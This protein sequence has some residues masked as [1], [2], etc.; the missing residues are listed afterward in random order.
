MSTGADCEPSPL[1]II[2]A[3]PSHFT[4]LKYSFFFSHCLFLGLSTH[5]GGWEA[6]PWIR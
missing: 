5:F 1:E 3:A 4:S 6:F 2:H